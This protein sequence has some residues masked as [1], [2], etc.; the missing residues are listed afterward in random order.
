MPEYLGHLQN[1]SLIDDP[2]PQTAF[3]PHERLRRPS[4]KDQ[5]PPS[6]AAV[7]NKPPAY[8]R[9]PER[10]SSGFHPLHRANR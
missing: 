3:R 7:P 9:R 8:S 6:T 1:D 4:R 5:R 2:F 10:C